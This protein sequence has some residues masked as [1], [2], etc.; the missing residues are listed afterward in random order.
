M[1][2]FLRSLV[3]TLTVL[4]LSGPFLTA[5][6][7][8]PPQ[9]SP[10]PGGL[11][12]LFL[13]CH[14][15]GCRD[16]DFF[17]TEI[18]FV[19]WVR[20]RMDADVHLLI[21]SQTTGAGGGAY[22]LLFIGQGRFEG[23]VDTIPYVSGFDATED[24]RRNGLAGITKVGLMR[25]V[26]LTPVAGEISIRM[27]RPGP[28]PGGGGPGRGQAAMA[29]PE[30]DP[31]DFWVFRTGV[32]LNS[33]GESTYRAIGLGASFTA[34]RT[35]EDFKLSLGFR[36]S[37]DENKFDYDDYTEL[38]VRRSHSFNGLVV[39]SLTEHWSAGLRGGSPTPPTTTTG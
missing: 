4:F 21:T 13:D 1:T 18:Q 17:R 10:Q 30:D 26:G 32:N 24:E 25:Y 6:E 38:S 31:W 27:G 12:R 11:V 9:E 22:E 23:M 16:Q 28:G 33:S 19:N 29:T 8:P 35:T 2:W 7:N 34:S 14:A 39:K 3:T 15:P 36:T 5:Q 37:Y 20:D